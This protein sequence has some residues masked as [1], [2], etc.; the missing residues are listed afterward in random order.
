MKVINQFRNVVLPL[1]IAPAKHVETQEL[2]SS[3]PR[4]T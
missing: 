4:Q 2:H 1:G 3:Y